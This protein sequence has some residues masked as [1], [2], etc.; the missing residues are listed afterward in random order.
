[1]IEFLLGFGV[2]VILVVGYAVWVIWGLLTGR[3]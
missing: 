2:A 1:M 3:R